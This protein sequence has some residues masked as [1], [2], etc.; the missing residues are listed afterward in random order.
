MFI[1][2]FMSSTQICQTDHVLLNVN[3]FGT[4]KNLIMVTVWMIIFGEPFVALKLMV[5]ALLYN[6]YKTLDFELNHLNIWFGL[7]KY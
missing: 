7:V 4:I 5:I 1:Q 3:T 6:E 2:E